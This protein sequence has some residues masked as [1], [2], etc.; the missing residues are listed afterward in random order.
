MLARVTLRLHRYAHTSWC[1]WFEAAL[2]SEDRSVRQEALCEAAVLEV[3]T[4]FSRGFN[5]VTWRRWCRSKLG[6]QS[7]TTG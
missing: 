4:P 1:S 6:R 3:F 2:C 5:R 7:S